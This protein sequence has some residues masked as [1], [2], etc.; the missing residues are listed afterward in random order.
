MLK[1]NGKKLRKKLEIN[2]KA[3]KEEEEK[4]EESEQNFSSER[5]S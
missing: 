4:E 5:S 3:S 2:G 1:I